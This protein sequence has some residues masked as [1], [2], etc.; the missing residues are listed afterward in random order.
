LIKTIAD[1]FLLALAVASVAIV[2]GPTSAKSQ[3]TPVVTAGPAN[4]ATAGGTLEKVTVTGYL[5]PRIGEGPQPV[6]T[7]DRD[8]IQKQAD[9]TVG[10]LIQRLPQSVGSLNPITATGISSSPGA[11]AV[12][13]KGLPYNATLVL[14]D[15]I[16]FPVYPFAINTANG[17]PI[18]FVDLNSFPLASVD[19]IEILKRTENR[20]SQ[21]LTRKIPLGFLTLKRSP[22]FSTRR[23]SSI[24]THSAQG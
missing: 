11:T 1:Q 22:A 4:S 2:L 5:F 24:S 10:D 18:S 14:V 20:S 13:L 16:R 12:G 19:R 23:R 6:I 15:G 9:Q 21:F 17:G 7:L 8:F 3:E